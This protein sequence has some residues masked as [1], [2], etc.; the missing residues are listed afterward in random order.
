MTEAIIPLS[1]EV[2]EPE[3]KTQKPA[4]GKRIFIPGW[5][6]DGL[7]AQLKGAPLAVYLAYL[8]F[9]NKEDHAWPSVKSLCKVTGYGADAVKEAR[10]ALIGASFITRI[11]QERGPGKRFG[12]TVFRVSRGMK[13]IP[14]S[15]GGVFRATAEPS[16]ENHATKVSEVEKVSQSKGTLR[17]RSKKSPR[18]R[19]TADCATVSGSTGKRKPPHNLEANI[20]AK[21]KAGAGEGPF[22]DM[23]DFDDSPIPWLGDVMA[24]ADAIGYTLEQ[25]SPLVSV[26]FV[27]AIC[28]AWERHAGEN[29]PPG[30][31]ATKVIDLCQSKDPSYR[32]PYP[33]DFEALRDRLR[34]AERTLEEK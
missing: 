4:R 6:R 32:T 5:V 8:S 29:L 1:T 18:K 22:A 12:R 27:A 23:L 34:E 9:A 16:T 11:G 28:E 30:I 25:H 2:S 17:Y 13:T 15:R 31:L 24:C 7:L 14:R 21:I 33:P 26:N 19:G 20:A 10:R 3:T